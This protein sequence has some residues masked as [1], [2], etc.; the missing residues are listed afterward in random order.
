LI[1]AKKE[2]QGGRWTNQKQGGSKESFKKHQKKRR[3]NIAYSEEQ[4]AEG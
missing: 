3:Q 4:A 1:K 2:S